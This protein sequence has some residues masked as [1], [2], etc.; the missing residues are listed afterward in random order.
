MN[1]QCEKDD[2]AHNE[3]HSC[4]VEPGEHPGST[5]KSLAHAASAYHDGAFSI[6]LEWGGIARAAV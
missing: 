5:G 1:L 2:R 3:P 4:S 6:H